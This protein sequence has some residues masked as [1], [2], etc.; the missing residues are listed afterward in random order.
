MM[1]AGNPFL[2]F[3]FETKKG[4]NSPYI[5]Q[6]PVLVYQTNDLQG[7]TTIFSKLEDAI[8]EGYYVAGCVSY[9]AAPAFDSTLSV[10]SHSA[11]PLVWFG[12][13]ERP[14]NIEIPAFNEPYH[15]TKWTYGLSYNQY[16]AAIGKIKDAIEAGNTYQINFTSRLQAQ[17]S[18]DDFS[19]YQQ[20]ARN[21]QAAYSAYLNLGRFRVLSASPE[22]FFQVEENRISAKPMKGTAKRGRFPSED[23]SLKEQL[24]QS[25]KEQAENVMIVDLIRNDI[26][27]I[28]VPGSVRVPDLFVVESYPTVHQ[29]TSTVEAELE[30][31]TTIFDWF[32]ALFPCGSI[33]GAPKRSTMNYI[34]ELEQSPRDVYCGAIGFI[35][36]KREAIFNVPI[37][38]VLL[39][40]NQNKAIYGV[41]GG[42]TWDS[43]VAGEYEEMAAKA[44]LLTER[45]PEFQLLESLAL[46]CGDYPL[47]NEHLNRLRDSARYFNFKMNEEDVKNHLHQLASTCTDG[48]HK[49]RLLI[50]RFGEVSTESSRISKTQEPV[51]CSLAKSPIDRRDPYLYHKTTNRT[52]YER[53][54]QQAANDVFSVLLWNE[55]NE[56]TEFTTGNVVLKQG[57]KFYTP[58]VTCGLLEGTFRKQLLDQGIIEEK[59]IN[60]E[61]L[62]E[63]DEIWFINGVRGWLRVNLI[64]S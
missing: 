15:V 54:Q 22:L 16:Q 4:R 12:V 9:E 14:A 61:D 11:F 62:A 60:K 8:D 29:M 48:E 5:F 53:H 24:K 30:E 55:Q 34:A 45:R 52:I 46:T 1:S 3:D 7:I 26:G 63:Y 64:F 42:I 19:F 28:A 21:Q 43:T 49:V 51:N 27:R 39:D 56:I 18:G 37:R 41:G 47:L 57:S 35:T 33:T 58:P 36:P 44:Q 31:H 20:L 25:K 38:T 17:F 13:F 23:L 40:T 6:D 32:Q 50:N 59:R 2:L 10:H